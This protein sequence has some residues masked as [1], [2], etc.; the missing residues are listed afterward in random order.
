MQATS[1]PLAESGYDST[2]AA[3]HV[4]YAASTI[5]GFVFVASSVNHFAN[6]YYLLSAVYSYELLGPQTGMALAIV[7]PYV[8]FVLAI[9]LIGRFWTG[10]A[11]LLSSGLLLVFLAAQC[12]AVA[13][14]LNISCGCFGPADTDPIGALSIAG[15]ALLC[16]GASVG[17]VCHL[18]WLRAGRSNQ[19]A[20]AD[21]VSARDDD[22]ARLA[23]N[24]N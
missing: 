19:V 16:A 15:V 4:S 23:G 14:G 12:S 3:K 17:Y 5:L 13:R 2:E 21:T 24:S 11:L 8:E 7:L 20:A 10:G 9:C 6:P 22:A 1:A 18:A